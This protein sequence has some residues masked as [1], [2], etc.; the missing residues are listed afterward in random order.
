ML[1][2]RCQLS[3]VLD[4]NYKHGVHNRPKDATNECQSL[5]HLR[6]RIQVSKS[7]CGYCNSSHPD[8][9]T[10]GSDYDSFLLTKTNDK[11]KDVKK[12]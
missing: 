9:V 2:F 8:G 6:L 11:V 12:S 3:L 10:L 5:T 7:N 1:L 4:C